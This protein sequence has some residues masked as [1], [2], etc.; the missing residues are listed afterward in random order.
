MS[1]RS[2]VLVSVL[3]RV[4]VP[5]VAALMGVVGAA[6]TAGAVA[7]V[8]LWWHLKLVDPGIDG[9]IAV[10]AEV[11][12]YPSDVCLLALAAIA[13]VRPL[14]LT[15]EHRLLVAG[16]TLLAAATLL[17]AFKALDP[18]RADGLAASLCRAGI[19]AGMVG[20]GVWWSTRPSSQRVGWPLQRRDESSRS[21]WRT[22]AA[23]GAL[24][25]T[26][27][28]LSPI[29][30]PLGGRLFPFGPGANALERGSIE[31]RL[32]LDRDAFLIVRDHLP[33]G[34]G[35]GNYG[36][37]ALAGAYQEGWGEPA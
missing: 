22:M 9:I 16:L 5:R 4:G 19:L 21:S 15:R 25:L 23:G 8:P 11:A 18:V 28:Y 34:V 27:V 10:F 6:A 37:A 2:V 14:A 35:G 13:V 12:I 36:L 3:P 32:A 17:S 20:L 26:V 30:E 29:A 33:F 1:A 31:N 24:A 7:L